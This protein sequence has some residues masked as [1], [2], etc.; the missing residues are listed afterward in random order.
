MAFG[1]H[2]KIPKLHIRERLSSLRAKGT[3]FLGAPFRRLRL[4]QNKDSFVQSNYA[5]SRFGQFIHTIGRVVRR[6]TQVLFVFVCLSIVA[7]G[8]GVGALYYFVT[9]QTAQETLTRFARHALDAQVTL[10]GP[11]TLKRLPDLVIEFPKLQLT[12]LD[13]DSV[14]A[15]IDSI[16]ARISLWSL[17]LGVVR[18]QDMIIRG[19]KTCLNQNSLVRTTNFQDAFGSVKFPEGLLIKNVRL[20]N[21]SVQVFTADADPP[22]IFDQLALSLGSISPEMESPVEASF[23]VSQ[24]L[25]GQTAAE[26]IGTLSLKA[27]LQFS[28]SESC[29]TLRDFTA[30]G[31]LVGNTGEHIVLASAKRLRLTPSQASGLAVRTSVCASDKT[32]GEVTLELAD[33]LIDDTRLATP[34]IK[35]SYRKALE[36]TQADFTVSAGLNINRETHAVDVTNISGSADAQGF[37]AS[38]LPITATVKGKASGNTDEESLVLDLVGSVGSSSFAYEG[39][40]TWDDFPHLNG[41]IRIDGIELENLPEISDAPWL[42]SMGFSGEIRVGKLRYAAL[43]AEQLSANLKLTDGV[44]HATDAVFTLA[45]GRIES[46]AQLNDDAQWSWEGTSEA[47]S[48]ESLFVNDTNPAPLTGTMTGHM[49]LSG[50]GTDPNALTGSGKARIFRGQIRGIEIAP[51][52]TRT[53]KGPHEILA[54][55]FDEMTCDLFVSGTTLSVSDLVVRNASSRLTGTLTVQLAE[56]TLSGSAQVLTVPGTQHAPGI[57]TVNMTGPITNPTWAIQSPEQGA[58]G[59]KNP[60]SESLIKRLRL[61]KNIRDFFSF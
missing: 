7:I 55:D 43:T 57:L 28:A 9:P 37:G 42:H 8:I 29:L 40:A 5:E 32:R 10:S 18:V 36:S 53:P 24:A 58:E 27:S 44:L 25:G 38:S 48:V 56:K 11:I 60:K 39:T 45:G 17:P 46:V 16:R 59:A 35:L 23:H 31:S 12:R 54:T 47:C 1:F 22:I 61:W 34:E 15:D 3:S 26:P 13:D 50:H 4:R 51:D 30:S 20:Q 21:T 41:T 6:I 33:F 2:F 49:R 52:H 14:L 19:L